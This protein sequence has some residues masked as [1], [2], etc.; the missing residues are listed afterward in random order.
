MPSITASTA[1][2]PAPTARNAA[3]QVPAETTVSPSMWR[4]MLERAVRD[5]AHLLQMRLRVREKDLLLDVLAQRCLGALQAVE[6]V[7]PQHLV[8][9]AHAVRPLGMPGAGV[10]LSKSRM[11]EKECRHGCACRV[12]IVRSGSHAMLM[13]PAR[14]GPAPLRYLTQA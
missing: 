14:Q 7:V 6:E 3:S 8:D 1:A 4:G 5:G 2:R 9:G 10:V 13:R 12:L 11:R